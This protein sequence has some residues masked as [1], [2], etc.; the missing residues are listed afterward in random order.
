MAQQASLVPKRAEHPRRADPFTS[1]P[2]GEVG[3]QRRVGRSIRRSHRLEVDRLERGLLFLELVKG[4]ALLREESLKSGREV[5]PLPRAGLPGQRV[6]QTIAVDAVIQGVLAQPAR[7]RFWVRDPSREVGDEAPAPPR[8]LAKLIQSSMGDDDPAPHDRDPVRHQLGFAQDVRGDDQGRAAEL[9]L[10]EV[11]AHVGRGHGI[12]AG[13]R[14]VAKDPV[15]IVERRADQRHL[16]GHATGIRGQDGVLPV[17][18]LE[19]LEQSRDAPAADRRRN[20]IQ[21]SEVVE[22]LGRGVAAIYSRLVRHHAEPG[23]NRVET[24]RQAEPIQLDEATV[25]PQ[26]AAEASQRCR[27]AGAV[28]SE[29]HKNLAPFDL[30]VDAGDGPY[31]AKALAQAFDPNHVD[32]GLLDSVAIRAGGSNLLERVHR[33]HED[34][35]PAHLDLDRVRHED[36]SRAEVPHPARPRR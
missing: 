15:R 22:V 11:P 31:I 20:A 12:E 16:L 1:P 8:L 33:H 3:A 19:T 10:V 6:M 29:E 34:C 23:T 4:R 7:H 36:L 18:E 32:R 24:L 21:V 13:C 9:L 26:D 14:L 30:Q 5:C 25:R 2:C 27:L 35:C 17:R 28:L